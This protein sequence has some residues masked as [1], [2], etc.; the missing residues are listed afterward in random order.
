VANRARCGDCSG[1]PCSRGVGARGP[2]HTTEHILRQTPD[3]RR[4]EAFALGLDA[5]A[6]DSRLELHEGEWRVLVGEADAQAASQALEGFDAEVD[7][8]AVVPLPLPPEPQSWLGP[9]VAILLLGGYLVTGPVDAQNRWF[10]PGAALSGKILAGQVY[11]TVTALTLHAHFAHVFGNA[12]VAFVLLG[13]IG[14]A[15]GPGV[16]SLLTLLAGAGGNWATAEWYGPGHASLGASTAIFGALGLL[17]VPGSWR[18]TSRWPAW[19]AV[20]ASLA[21]LGMLGSS[22]ESDVAA[23]LF[24]WMAGAVLGLLVGRRPPIRSWVIQVLCGGLTVATV[25]GCWV[26]ALR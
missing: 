11:R 2:E 10:D 26:L 23:H 22:R 17:T 8:M 7:A 5:A 9:F 16:A 1:S 6:I 25:V 13:A 3:R 24:G 21:L 14:Q 4:A 15:L 12:V 20:G 19:V 18:R